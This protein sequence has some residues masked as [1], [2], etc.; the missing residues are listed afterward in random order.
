MTQ[1]DALNVSLRELLYEN[2]LA[3]Q[4][5]IR[6]RYKKTFTDSLYTMSILKL[7]FTHLSFRAS[8]LFILNFL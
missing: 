7:V 5:W 2:I 4:A 3:K 1:T 6:Y 8:V